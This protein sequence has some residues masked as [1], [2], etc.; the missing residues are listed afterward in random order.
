MVR[1]R[2]V[3]VLLRWSVAFMSR[4]SADIQAAIL[5]LASER[6]PGGTICPSEAAR[7]LSD[8]HP[9]Q[10]APLMGAVRAAAVALA[11]SGHLVIYRKGKPVDPRN[12]RGVYRL[13]LPR[14]D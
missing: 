5:A 2:I 13:G 6:G 7:A 9:D 4:T 1:L 8:R 11:E 10:W 3:F 14:V 12:F